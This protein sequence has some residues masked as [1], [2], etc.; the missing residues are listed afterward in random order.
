MKWHRCVIYLLFV[1]SACSD[2]DNAGG[3]KPEWKKLGLDGKTINELYLSGSALYAGTTSGFFRKDMNSASDFQLIGFEG[4]NVEAID[5]SSADEILVSIFD[6]SGG[7][8]PALYTTTD[9]GS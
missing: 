1:L 7:E 2:D 8:P 5:V 4:K 9:G 6:K 3:K